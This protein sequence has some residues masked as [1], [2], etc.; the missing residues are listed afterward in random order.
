M[1]EA[2]RNLVV[3][4]WT[5]S[6]IES[7][8]QAQPVSTYTIEEEAPVDSQVVVYGSANEGE[9][10]RHTVFLEQN[11]DENPLGNPIQA[12]STYDNVSPQIQPVV[13]AD[14]NKQSLVQSNII[15][16]NLPQNPKI[17]AQ[18]SPQ[19]VGKQIQNTLYESGGRIYDLQSYPVSDIKYI[20]KPNLNPTIT[21]YPAY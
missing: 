7:N 4:I 3:L 19:Q 1:G 13:S 15:Q 18:E 14:I 17:S 21:T 6:A 16:E 11:N 5:F 2:V 10:H 8:A 12:Y 20:E 9:G